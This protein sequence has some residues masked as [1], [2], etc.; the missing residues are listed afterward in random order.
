MPLYVCVLVLMYIVTILGGRGEIPVSHPLVSNPDVHV[1]VPECCKNV[2]T[3]TAPR[4]Q[5]FTCNGSTKFE[6]M[7]VQTK[8]VLYEHLSVH[9]KILI[10]SSGVISLESVGKKQA[11]SPEY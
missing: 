7:Y 1:G 8:M 5:M 6:Y 4:V 9:S 11:C 2:A 3:C 10:S